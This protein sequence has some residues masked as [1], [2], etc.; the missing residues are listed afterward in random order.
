M[1]YGW[2]NNNGEL[3]GDSGKDNIR[4]CSQMIFCMPPSNA[5]IDHKVVNGSFDE[6]AYLIEAVSFFHIPLDTRKHPQFH[7]FV[8]IRCHALSGGGTGTFTV[9]YPPHF[10]H[11]NFWIAPFDTVSTSFFFG[12]AEVFHGEVGIIWTGG[13]PVFIV[14]D[15]L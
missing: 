10:Y 7:V 14:T 3:A 12:D 15:F 4:F 8:G 2:C 11:M 9:T 13:I 1:Y 5:H 6:R